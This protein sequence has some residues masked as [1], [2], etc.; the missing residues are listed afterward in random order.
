MNTQNTTQNTVEIATIIE[1]IM[2]TVVELAQPTEPVMVTEVVVAK[3]AVEPTNNETTVIEPKSE[4]EWTCELCNITVK[5]VSKYKHMKTKKHV[6]KAEK[7]NTEPITEESVSDAETIDCPI[8]V[9]VDSV[10]VDSVN[11]DSV[12]VDSVNESKSEPQWTCDICNITVKAVSKYKHMKTKKHIQKAEK[13]TTEIVT[14]PTNETIESVTESKIEPVTETKETVEPKNETIETITE[15]ITERS[16]VVIKPKPIVPKKIS[17]PFH[18]NAL[19]LLKPK[20]VKPMVTLKQQ[21]RVQEDLLDQI[22]QLKHALQKAEERASWV[23]QKYEQLKFATREMTLDEFVEYENA[24][25]RQVK[26]FNKE[27]SCDEDEVISKLVKMWKMCNPAEFEQRVESL[28]DKYNAYWEE[29][30]A[31]IDI[32]TIGIMEC[33]DMF[34]AVD[35]EFELKKRQVC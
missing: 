2:A 23:E 1:P 15:T 35:V 27:L 12:N 5:A 30:S 8:E 4:P 18:A 29:D 19:P 26:K 33:E 21:D 11:V 25:R 7:Q 22:T 6:Q 9:P 24:I 10:N 20:P 13:T 3:L 28:L 32:H 17:K 16:P 31:P 34:G 14:E